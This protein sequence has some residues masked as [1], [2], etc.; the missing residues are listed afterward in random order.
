MP[1]TSTNQ[2][3]T[4]EF[5]NA[6]DSV[7]PI[8]IANPEEEKY[9]INFSFVRD[10]GMIKKMA[11]AIKNRKEASFYLFTGH[12]GCGKSTE[13]M[14]LR[15]ELEERNFHVVYCQAENKVDLNDLNVSD[16]LLAIAWQILENLENTAPHIRLVPNHFEKLCRDIWNFL[17]LQVTG[18]KENITPAELGFR[19]L[20]D[21]TFSLSSLAGEIT[22]KSKNTPNIRSLLHDYLGFQVQEIL[23]IINQELIEPAKT[24]LKAQGKAGL[25]II[26]DDLERV[27]DR[28]M[29][30]NVFQ[31]EY[32]FINQGNLLRDLNCHKV[33]TIPAKLFFSPE[34]QALGHIGDP[35]M[36]PIVPV[37]YQNGE[38]NSK[39]MELLRQMVLARAFPNLLPDERSQLITLLFDS[40]DTLD[41]VCKMSGGHVRTLITFLSNSCKV[42]Q[43][44]PLSIKDVKKAINMKRDELRMVINSE[45]WISLAKVAKTHWVNGLQEY[46]TLLKSLFVFQYE[47]V[48]GKS[49]SIPNTN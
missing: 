16:L 8:N 35:M 24:Q 43:N 11:D 5:F 27:A 42:D 48:M 45:Q 31:P 28:V 33:F 38:E 32:L 15:V 14:R 29:P 19:P 22:L 20:D 21:Q 3:N 13:L 12:I 46:Q 25:V 6:C 37:F 2:L 4:R 1:N 10:S 23:K 47:S 40:E 9:Y 36:L 34:R 30:N 17:T 44:P 49:G 7:R 41:L 26:I 39:G 18:F